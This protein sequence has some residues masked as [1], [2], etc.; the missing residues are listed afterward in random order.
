MDLLGSVYTAIR[1]F[2]KA[3]F[4]LEEALKIDPEYHKAR[5]NLGSLF[6]EQGK[7]SVAQPLLEEVRKTGL[8]YYDLNLYLGRI[9]L[10][11]GEK[12]AALTLLKD[13]ITMDGRRLEG[14]L[15]T[16]RAYES[17][18]DFINAE[19][20]LLQ[21]I[22]TDK[23]NPDAYFEIADFYFRNRLQ[24]KYNK[25][26][27]FY[28]KTLELDS[29]YPKREQILKNIEMVSGKVKRV[30]NDKADHN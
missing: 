6:F 16:G 19:K 10:K 30:Q 20:V 24:D 9:Y 8:S 21:G 7:Y 17:M 22:E 23:S 27:E 1:N 29:K 11:K 13:L 18:N 3:Q 28:E 15:W 26:V 14:Y 2:E 12:E 25:C 5:M 4:Y